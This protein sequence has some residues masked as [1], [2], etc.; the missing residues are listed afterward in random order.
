MNTTS[1]LILKKQ[2]FL[3]FALLSCFFALA[4]E[5][6]F[7]MLR[8]DA[9]VNQTELLPD[10]MIF[11][12]RFLW[13]EKGLM[14]SLK[15]SPLTL[16]QREKELKIRRKMLKAHQIIGFVTLAG[17]VAQGIMGTQMY[18][19]DYSFKEAHETIG[20]LTSI[21]Y[22][23]GAGL[24]LFA[25]PPLVHKKTKGL[26]SSQA[27]KYLATIHFSAMVATNL[28]AEENTK[29]HR[30]SAFAAFGSYATAILVFKF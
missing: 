24:S 21:S 2:C 23:T 9:E 16:E 15:V 14:R 11:T 5:D 22:F 18:K 8:E 20:N 29:L 6:L 27:H 12:Q 1:S 3:F 7:G 30:A 25:P 10:K 4:Q 13:G 26:S 17:M 28:L 19:G